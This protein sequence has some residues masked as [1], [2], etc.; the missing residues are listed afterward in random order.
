MKISE[1]IIKLEKVE[2]IHGDMDVKVW[3]GPED[4]D[5]IDA[6]PR[7]SKDYCKKTILII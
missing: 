3:S 2:K 4:D 5:L 6:D 7:V 1:L